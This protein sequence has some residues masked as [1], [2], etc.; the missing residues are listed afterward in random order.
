MD[1]QLFKKIV[2][3]FFL[4]NINSVQSQEERVTSHALGINIGMT[5]GYGLSYYYEI[6]NVGFQITGF[7]QRESSSYN[8]TH[9]G[10]MI[11]HKFYKKE[12][13]EWFSYAGF[14]W[15]RF[16]MDDSYFDKK[17]QKYF[18]RSKIEHHTHAGIGH[19]IAW[20]LKDN[21][22]LKTQIGYGLFHLETRKPQ[23]FITGE[24][25]LFYIL[26]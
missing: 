25:S 5:T 10:K 6:H 22:T 12:N 4:L 13:F 14:F 20:R 23:S 9:L 7:G 8:S 24:L 16:K 21:F 19:G 2:L 17:Q 15:R 18:V 1:N 26:F 11:Y 3:L